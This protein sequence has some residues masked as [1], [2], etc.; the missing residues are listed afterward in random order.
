MRGFL[1]R[2][3]VA[4]FGVV[5][6]LGGCPQTADS[7]VTPTPDAE[8]NDTFEAA[9]EISLSSDGKAEF[10]ARILDTADY[11]VFRIG[12]LSTG[13]RLVIDVQADGS[14]LDAIA[15]VF[16]GDENMYAFNDDRESDASNLNP[17]IDVVL[18]GPQSDYF[19]GVAPFPNSGST[20][21]YS[22]QITV[23]P[24][25]ASDAPTPQTV[26]MNWAGGTNVVIEN[27]GTFS[28]TP[29]DAE[30][31]G[32]STGSTNR[33]KDLVQSTVAGRFAGFALTLLNSDDAARPAGVHSTIYFGGRNP[34]AFAI[35]EQIDTQNSDPSDN[36]ILFSSS[37]VSA[38]SID[39]TLEQM[40]TAMGNTIAHEI[41]HLLGMVHT[42]DCL[43][44]MDTRC[45]NDALLRAQAFGLAPLDSTVFPVGEQ[46]AR[47]L[48]EYTIGLMQP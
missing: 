17:F 26:F 41:S 34:N 22:V 25:S 47:A 13:D 14:S 27:V 33:L 12:T 45:G 32:F 8:G 28:L 4:S 19:L 18:R 20:G 44:L 48:L 10:D 21:A 31:V 40:A 1:I 9:G 3:V 29:F 30:D 11:D 23:I 6:G 43:E 36:A 15:A 38:F 16:D 37:F 39:P 5:L 24:G 2:G 42:R 46:D 7:V 35:S